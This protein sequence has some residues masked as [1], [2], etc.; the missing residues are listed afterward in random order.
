MDNDKPLPLESSERS[1][2]PA[3]SV[4]PIEVDE[5]IH[6]S[7]SSN[8]RWVI[9]LVIIVVA[10]FGY[11][12]YRYQSLLKQQMVPSQQ[13]KPTEAVKHPTFPVSPKI[14]PTPVVVQT[15]LVDWLAEP[16]K[17]DS[18]GFFG[19]ID[20]YYPYSLEYCQSGTDCS[21]TVKAT[22][23][24]EPKATYYKV[25]TMRSQYAGSPVYMA[26]VKGL[27]TTH[28]FK[29]IG[30]EKDFAHD[31]ETLAVFIKNK[32]GTFIVP[33]DYQ[34]QSLLCGSN[35]QNDTVLSN[36]KIGILYDKSISLDAPGSRGEYRDSENAATYSMTRTN[37]LFNPSGLF[38]VKNFKDG[39][40]LYSNEDIHTNPIKLKSIINTTFV[41]RLPTGLAAEAHIGSNYDGFM[42][43]KDPDPNAYYPYGEGAPLVW[44]AGDPPT[45]LP[46]PVATPSGMMNGYKSIIYTPDYDGCSG[47]MTLDGVSSE[48]EFLDVEHNLIAVAKTDKGDTFYD[49]K[50]KDAKVFQQFWFFKV[51]QP[52][53]YN[54]SYDDYLKLK[55]ILIWKN[56]L[57]VYRMVF[58]AELTASKCWAEPLIY[59][60]PTK[61]TDVNIRLDD[62]ITLT[63]TT[64]PYDKGW[65]VIAYPGGKIFSSSENRFYPYL[66]W[67]GSAPMGSEPVLQKVV[68]GQGVHDYFEKALTALGLSTKEKADFESYWEPKLTGSPYYLISFYDKRSLDLVAPL[69]ITPSPDT[70]IRI[71]MSYTKLNGFV[72]IP[73]ATLIN[74][75]TPKRTGFTVVEWGGIL[76]K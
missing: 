71:L 35:C 18:V 74:Y 57:G 33:N 12:G 42:Y 52:S 25:G 1:D 65:N 46:K 76:H 6:G 28:V 5:Q 34:N 48:S 68:M 40:V 60:Y 17:V 13:A 39:Y 4:D 29:G 31:Y 2:S 30:T 38:L 75:Q 51:T 63:K 44:T 50:T 72:D 49:L 69:H 59:L 53:I 37:N 61:Q 8:T 43:K 58:R 24:Y 67:E 55:P 26:I 62:A 66:F 64:P 3:Q 9:L 70:E 56:S 45:E 47:T 15:G 32:D 14:T 22:D 41:L 7:H 54:L 11:L 73:A 16:Q 10:G 36:P 27:L 19:V 21:K 20:Q 23:T